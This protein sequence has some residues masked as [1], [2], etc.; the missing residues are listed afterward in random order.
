MT[1]V[2]A[3]L[4]S[5]R[6]GQGRGTAEIAEELCI[7]QRY[8]RAIEND[9]LKCLPGTFFYKSFAR[10]YA[11]VLGI[12]YKH[13]Q[14][15]M[16]QLIAGQQDRSMPREPVRPQESS[17]PSWRERLGFDRKKRTSPPPVR[18]PDPIVQSSNKDY[19]TDGRI[20]FPMAILAVVLL[21][22][23]GFYAWWNRPPQARVIPPKQQAELPLP[24]TVSLASPVS[25]IE[26]STD[27]EHLVLNL[28]ATERTWLSI[29]SE[30]KEI[31]SGI[32]QPSQTKT[33]TAQEMAKMKVGNAGGIEIRLNGK[34]IGPIGS[35]GQVKT[36]L[37]TRDNF[38]ILEPK[39]PPPPAETL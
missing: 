26:L 18:E 36:I 16:E 14:A 20:G 21:A 13:I 10:Q 22:C 6:E 23:S 31:F 9:D 8:L 1:S 4:R 32:L 17:P 39:P 34:E 11:A 15:G 27:Q 35:S 24:Q 12:P 38:E 19:F 37:F 2:G 28:S 29:T 3:I 33:L 30:G 25:A 5:A 7:I